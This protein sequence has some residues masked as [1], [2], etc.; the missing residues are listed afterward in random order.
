MLFRVL[1]VCFLVKILASSITLCSSRCFIF[2]YCVFL[3]C[4][5]AFCVV[6]ELF[7]SFSSLMPLLFHCSISSS[8]F[9]VHFCY[10]SVQPLSQCF[11]FIFLIMQSKSF[12]LLF[13]YSTS[14][15]D[16]LRF[17]LG[18]L[19]FVASFS[20]LK[21]LKTTLSCQVFS[22]LHFLLYTF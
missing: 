3:L 8:V 21:F 17:S 12:G 2:F 20:F 15:L 7:F 1:E 5:F 18:N 6:F 10:F 9:F 14:L 16:F 19:S 11:I 13:S 22:T 4:D